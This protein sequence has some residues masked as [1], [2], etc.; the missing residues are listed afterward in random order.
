MGLLRTARKPPIGLAFDIADLMHLQSWVASHDVRMV[1]ELDHWM[2]GE[3]YE[4]VVAFYAKDGSLRHGILWRSATDIV[5]QPLIGRTCRFGSVADARDSLL[6][7]RPDCQ[8]HRPEPEM[9]R[10]PHRSKGQSAAPRRAKHSGAVR[11]GGT[12]PSVR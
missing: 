2:E 1:V 8:E 3:E 6:G 5:A 12:A 10:R 11:D 4:E 9:V 7:V